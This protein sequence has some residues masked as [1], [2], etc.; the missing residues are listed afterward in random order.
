VG[1]YTVDVKYESKYYETIKGV[2]VTATIAK[3]AASVTDPPVAITD[4]KYNGTSQNLVN[5]SSAK[6]V[7]GKLVYAITTDASATGDS[8][9]YSEGAPKRKDRGTYYVWY[10]VAGD[11][12]HSDSTPVKLEVSIAK[13]SAPTSLTDE[14]KPHAKN[15]ILYRAEPTEIITPPVKLPSEYAIRYS[16]GGTTWTEEPPTPST[17]GEYTVKVKYISDNYNDFDGTDITVTITAG[18]EPT[19]KKAPTANEN[20]EFGDNPI[21]ICDA[22][23][24]DPDTGYVMVYALG[25]DNTTWPERGDYS[26]RIPKT[27]KPGTYYVW[28][29]YSGD[30]THN[31][32]VP[33]CL[34][35]VI[36][37]GAAPT[38][39]DNQK[40][41][42]RTGLTYTGKATELLRGPVE[43][44]PY[45][46]VIEYRLKGQTEWQKD[47]P[48]G[49]D[50]KTYTVETRYTSE[51]YEDITI[52]EIS[53][54]IKASAVLTDNQ[55]PTPTK[56]PVYTGEPI[57]TLNKPK[58][59]PPTG[60]IMKYALGE[61]DETA[62]APEKFKEEIPECIDAGTYYVWYKAEGIGDVPD[63]VPVCI[64]I[65]IDKAPAPAGVPTTS[66][67]P[68]AVPHPVYKG[69]PVLIVNPPAELPENYEIEYS[70]DNGENWDD[71][72][73]RPDK[74]GKYIV[75]TKYHSKNYKD[76]EG[77]DIT[78]TVEGPVT[79]QDDQR[80]TANDQK[81]A[82]EEI[83]LLN[84]PKKPAPENYRI[85]YASGKDNTN[86]P[87]SYKFTEDI[88]TTEKVGTYYVWYKFVGDADHSD[89]DAVCI[90]VTISKGEAPAK[91][92]LTDGQKPKAKENLVYKGTPLE[93]VDAPTEDAP[94]SYKIKYSTDNKTFSEDIPKSSSTG[95][96]TVYVKYESDLY[97]DIVI[98]P[99]IVKIAEA[100]TVKPSQKPTATTDEEGE[101]PIYTGKPIPTVN[102]PDEN[103]PTGYEVVYA[104]GEDDKKVPSDDKFKKDI[105]T[106]TDAG[107]YYTWF[108]LVGDDEHSDTE[109]EVII[110]VIEK[111]PAPEGEPTEAHKPKA[112][113]DPVYK[114]KPVDIITPPTELPKGYEIKYSTDG[115][116]TWTDEV[117]KADG[118]G[119]T[120][121]KVKYVSK[122]YEDIKG[123]DIIVTV[124][125]ANITDD[126]QPTVR[127]DL[128]YTG[129]DQELVNKPKEQ[130]PEGYTVKYAL[131]TDDK[132]V[133]ED[134][135][136]GTTIPKGK[137]ADTYYVWFVIKGGEKQSDFGPVCLKA[138]IREADAPT[139]SLTDNYKPTSKGDKL[140]YTGDPVI[141]VNAPKDELPETYSGY[142]PVYSVDDGNSW[143]TELPTG[144]DP[145]TY[146]ILVKFENKN[147]KDVYSDD[148]TATIVAAE[149]LKDD[150]IPAGKK[151]LVYDG[152]EQE[153]VEGPVGK[154]PDDYVIKYALGEDDTKIPGSKDFGTGIPKGKKVG[155]YHVWYKGDTDTGKGDTVPRCID[156][157]IKK[158]PATLK[159]EDI[160]DKQKPHGVEE[161]EYKGKPIE[162][163]IP[164]A[165]K[166]E[167]YDIIEYS[168]DGG[169]T[170][171]EEIPTGNEPG[172]YTVEVRYKSTDG[173]HEDVYGEPIIVKIIEEK[174]EL[175]EEQKPQPK[176]GKAATFT[177]DDI[178][179]L[180]P[181]VDDLPDGYTIEYAIGDDPTTPPS[182]D[183]FTDEI[184]KGRDAGEYTVW[185]I[186][187]GDDTHGDIGPTPI[188]VT[189]LPMPAPELT[190]DQKPTAVKDGEGN[191]PVYTGKTMEVINAPKEKIDDYDVFYAVSEDIE[192][193]PASEDAYSKEVPTGQD[194]GEYNIWFK[195]VRT[196]EEGEKPSNYEESK[197]ELIEAKILPVPA[198]KLTEDQKPKPT[199][200]EDGEDL[201]YTG[202]E[203]EL[204]EEPKT[205]LT[206]DY[207][208]V[209]AL[210]ENDVTAP[211]DEEFSEKVPATTEA[212][213]YYIWFKGKAP[214]KN[215]ADTDPECIVVIINKAEHDYTDSYLYA[216]VSP[217]KTT[218]GNVNLTECLFE[219]FNPTGGS[220]TT[221]P[222]GDL[223]KYMT[224][225]RLDGESLLYDITGEI[226]V[227]T[228][229][230]MVVTLTS[231][232][233]TDANVHL[234][235]TTKDKMNSVDMVVTGVMDPVYYTGKAIKMDD[236][237]VYSAGIKL[238][239]KKDYTV[240]YKNNKNAGTA[241]ITVTGKGNYKDKVTDT[242]QILP[243]DIGVD[244]ET[245]ETATEGQ[246]TDW[247]SA[248][249]FFLSYTGKKQKKS[250]KLLWNGLKTVAKSNYTISYY[251]PVYEADGVTVSKDP[252]KYAN[253][254]AES[255]FKETYVMLLKVKP[256]K[257][258]KTY[259]F[260][261]SRVVVVNILNDKSKA[262]LSKA[263]VTLS[264]K[265]FVYVTDKD[266]NG[267]IKPTVTV[268]I[269][270][271][272]YKEG[273]DY[274]VSYI[275][276]KCAGTGTVIVEAITKAK[277]VEGLFGEKK[278]KFTIK[279]KSISKVAV[280]GFSSKVTYDPFSKNGITQDMTKVV[281]KDGSAVLHWD[282]ETGVAKPDFSV[283]YKNNTKAGNATFVITGNNNYS[284]SKKVKFKIDQ[285]EL[286]DGKDKL[287][288]TT[289][290]TAMYSKA[291]AKTSVRILVDGMV[292][293]EKTDYK[294]T[295]AKNKN[296]GVDAEV[297]ITGKGNY[298]GT[299]T[300][301]YKVV[302]CE[303]VD[304]DGTLTATA[305]DLFGKES[306]KTKLSSFLKIPT[307]A[308]TES[309][310]KLVKN[311]DF[312]K[313]V[314]YDISSVST[315]DEGKTKHITDADMKAA[316]ANF[317]KGIAGI[318]Y[319]KDGV[320]VK[321]T[322]TLK[323][324]YKG[325]ASTVYHITGNKIASAKYNKIQKTYTSK[326]IVLKTSADDPKNPDLVLYVGKNASAGTKLVYGVDYEI[327]P[328]TYKNNIKKGTAQVTIR[329]IGKYEGTKVIKFKIVQK[330]L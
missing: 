204:V 150:Q 244:R 252:A 89:T 285:Y 273:T 170:W 66:Q 73:P 39:S 70:I 62:P 220:I 21:P 72:P 186:L 44:L 126:Q 228:T 155:T 34:T 167:G 178:V 8:L 92:T 17:P 93:L 267:E 130:A 177:G 99:I 277:G 224:N 46:Y 174:P 240:K 14:Q 168:I 7:G 321:A 261:G 286:K 260:T 288:I 147:K 54:E 122:N 98:D 283:S 281:V 262:L 5:A 116:E 314:S 123:D 231:R 319:A 61:N 111:A 112:V 251:K 143:T 214:D 219:E 225:L 37:K 280:T 87:A 317:I 119:T 67:K 106:Q 79:I 160:T 114:G 276:N 53:A 271:K 315:F 320:Y 323:G 238:A 115:G 65:V 40:P 18:P 91:D 29:K 233:Y 145:G 265:S 297:K 172:I 200:G 216:D 270:K 94:E 24:E 230:K 11:A 284:G 298:K 129:S 268:K 47:I 6:V 197:P 278:V 191:F 56:D 322:V 1:T 173:D 10:K 182:E 32:S 193:P 159:P 208:M 295:F 175:T 188:V 292:L 300:R 194:A 255:A 108:K 210:G 113:K 163:V 151:D 327:V 203:V 78:V 105:P 9:S 128:K 13:G 102:K 166:P 109:P 142:V 120:K 88:P 234:T 161:Q 247:F 125:E 131:G 76:I 249:D 68:T 149:P 299:V 101:N 254:A 215:H 187:E 80:P 296:A 179:L 306:A 134:K 253:A 229:G 275:D 157:E 250:P 133:P 140:P 82:G 84:A 138:T 74:P 36:K 110:T 97:D 195:V 259:N 207:V 43:D 304:G 152:N 86:V 307:V 222:S 310:K 212:G 294:L 303:V 153:L 85:K 198:P 137:D 51:Y 2:T 135:D 19:G 221:D 263:K 290:K 274:K 181:P 121:V 64:T 232:N 107:T 12:N 236:L 50:A 144:T 22:P 77:E 227:G 183:A 41:K 136:F 237:A 223:F 154:L 90:T 213:V 55:V 302:P 196:P 257:G 199:K 325:T 58:A 75:K 330:K 189:I 305:K 243:L 15:P 287:K 245:A 211:A 35:V 313:A 264:K 48:T 311:K 248:D 117:P 190:E 103:P 256:N 324:N 60:T 23:E 38:L 118:P 291:G 81:Y 301:K 192:N 158:A 241:S 209:Y 127:K 206:D 164:P 20:P 309:G 71:D 202:Q 59:D 95:D 279:R 289:D 239:L 185:Y 218:E 49:T 308:E 16:I 3:A 42:A 246:Q 31:D 316:F 176:Q 282:G 4:L 328:G 165:E 312:E 33:K 63:T 293:A 272:S 171:S 104:P 266:K 226:P 83:V 146:D 57:K 329:G 141:L 205:E 326:E 28:Y 269:G 139:D 217:K 242:F 52:P 45:G 258:K 69:G 30:D 124:P 25:K 169:E 156:V 148:L 184:P 235:L 318:Q 162:L 96:N 201:V 26:V 27:T 132:K 100:P 180:E